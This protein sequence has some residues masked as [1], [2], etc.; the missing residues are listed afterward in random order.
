MRSYCMRGLADVG[1]GARVVIVRWRT[2][3]CV[4]ALMM[5][6]FASCGGRTD[7][8]HEPTDGS[9]DEASACSDVGNAC[10]SSGCCPGLIC[11]VFRPPIKPGD[12]FDECMKQ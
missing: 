9:V 10:G 2:L 6:A 5:A 8:G 1:L 7:L 4:L 3:S 12:P 11:E